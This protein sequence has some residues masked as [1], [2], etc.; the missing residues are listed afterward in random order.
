VARIFRLLLKLL[1]AG[2]FAT[3]VCTVVWEMELGGKYYHVD[4]ATEICPEGF[5]EPGEWVD[6]TAVSV[7]VVGLPTS[8]TH[9]IDRKFYPDHIQEGWTVARLWRVWWWFLAA[10]IGA[11]LGLWLLPWRNTVS[12]FMRLARIHEDLAGFV[13]VPLAILA[14]LSMPV[15]FDCV[16]ILV[17]FPA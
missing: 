14:F 4:D 6:D 8:W 10:D 15:V 1:I 5:L 16:L 9:A 13:Y 12:R 7:K 11:T 3:D 2:S 17:R